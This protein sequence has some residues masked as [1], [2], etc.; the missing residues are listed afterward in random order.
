[1]DFD[2]FLNDLIALFWLNLNPFKVH[3]IIDISK[4]TQ[5]HNKKGYYQTNVNLSKL[6]DMLSDGPN[7]RFMPL[8]QF[9]AFIT[10]RITPLVEEDEALISDDNW[11]NGVVLVYTVHKEK[12]VSFPIVMIAGM[13]ENLINPEYFSTVIIDPINLSFKEDVFKSQIKDIE[14]EKSIK[15]YINDLLEEE[16]RIFYVSCTRAKHMLIFLSCKNNAFNN[17]HIFWAK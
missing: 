3:Y 6:R 10:R 7:N 8:I 15:N 13:D 4:L 1:M 9:L 12:E 5:Y 16:L 2:K 17:N 14:Y 11:K